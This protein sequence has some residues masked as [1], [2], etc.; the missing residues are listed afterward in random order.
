MRT[1]A[2]LRRQ[3]SLLARAWDRHVCRADQVREPGQSAREVRVEIASSWDRS[4]RHI[5]PAVTQAPLAEVDE[6]TAAWEFSP[7][8]AA[9]RCLQAELQSAADA[10][11]LVV[12]VTDPAA[13]ILWTYGG[14]AM[15]RH[16]EEVNFVPCGRWDEASVGT[17]ALDLALRLDLP[18]TV[19]SAEHYSSCVHDWVCWAAPVHD[20]ATGRQLGVLDLSTTWDR[21]HPI[22]LATASALARLIERE[23]GASCQPDD[24]GPRPA[25]ATLEIRLLG[26]AVVLLAGRRLRLPR[27][28]VE[29]LALLALQ[30][31]GLDLGQ[32]HAQLY[33]DRQVS[34][35]T[36]K[37][38]ISH[39]RALLGG[40]VKSRPYQLD[41]PVWC[42]VT[43]VIGKLQ[44]GDVAA[45]V[46]SYGGD[47]LSW[48]DSPTL[49][50]YRHF[51]TAAVRNALLASPQHTA[52]LR[53]GLIAPYDLEPVTAAGPGA[54]NR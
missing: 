13:R 35:G 29:I 44:A 2:E 53:Y 17:N 40:R 9:V 12:A 42:D 51:V 37:A 50:D 43:D 14:P 36:L 54:T 8:S 25:R 21:A 34:Q 19:Y 18:A 4:A 31:D 41:L 7:L 52:A 22:G 15:R 23:V 39:L 11:D 26:R 48:S 3:R 38:E 49:A 30:P 1:R 28:Q 16:A 20:S 24:P 33:G 32:L 47:L 6:T 5:S 46:E 10:A 45:A 27:R